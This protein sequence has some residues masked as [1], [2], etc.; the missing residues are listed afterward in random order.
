MHV[1]INVMAFIF[2]DSLKSDLKEIES[3]IGKAKLKPKGK[4]KIRS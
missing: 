2:M 3:D 4:V 1:Y